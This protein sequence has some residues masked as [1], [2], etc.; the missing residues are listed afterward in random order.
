[1]SIYEENRKQEAINKLKHAGNQLSKLP[2]KV[3]PKHLVSL[4]KKVKYSAK[5]IS[6]LKG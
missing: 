4:K 1:M 2:G 6:R 3:K 5:N